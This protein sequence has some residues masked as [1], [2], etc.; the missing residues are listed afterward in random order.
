M[1]KV[2]KSFRVI[3]KPNDTIFEEPENVEEKILIEEA[4]KKYESILEKANKEAEKIITEAN[5]QKE[6]H[7]NQAYENSKE[8]F[9]EFREKGYNEGYNIGYKE[10]NSEGYSKGYDEGKTESDKLIQEA[11]D[12]KNECMKTKDNIYRE[13]EEDVIQLVIDICEKVIYEKIDED[14]EYIVSLILKGIESLNATENLV[15]RVPREDYD[16]VEMSKD[17]IL[18]KAS[19]IN[20]LEVKADSNLDKGDCIIETSSGNVDMSVQDQVEKVK[21]LLNNILSSE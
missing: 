8:L 1:S 2:I 18:V 12:I 9:K 14:K 11:I 4:K 16:I 21:K 3:E 20:E 19:L 13:I 5:E 6:N 7:L 15:V 17:K 10:G